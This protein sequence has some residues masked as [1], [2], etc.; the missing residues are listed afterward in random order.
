MFGFSCAVRPVGIRPSAPAAKCSGSLVVPGQREQ[1]SSQ[2]FVLL[3]LL[4]ASGMA[5]VALRGFY[6]FGVG[7]GFVLQVLIGVTAVALILQLHFAANRRLM[8][9]VSS[10]LV[11][12][13]YYT[14]RLEKFSYVD[15]HTDL[16]NRRYLE[17]LFEQQI[18]WINRRGKAATLLLFEVAS[19]RH[20]LPSEDLIV[21]AAR[22]LR[23]NF[24]GSD[25]IVRSAPHQLLVLMPE[26]TGDEAHFAL[27]RLSDKVDDWNLENN[28][29]A[30]MLRH[31][32]F[33]CFPGEDLWERLR[34]LEEKFCR[35]APVLAE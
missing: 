9:E 22:I 19:E 5:V 7:S 23:S 3:L 11:A 13:T 2:R 8:R 34:G 15:P 25:Y 26:T 21:E 27:N 17:Q 28:Y 20:E 1:S 29:L 35:S 6:G 32:M 14:E 10:A 30:M 18:K 31:E 24:R 12:A 16:F 33:V 4:L